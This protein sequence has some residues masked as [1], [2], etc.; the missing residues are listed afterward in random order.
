MAAIPAGAEVLMDRS[1]SCE[2]VLFNDSDGSHVRHRAGTTKYLAATYVGIRNPCG[3]PTSHL[4]FSGNATWAQGEFSLA[5]FHFLR[6]PMAVA[7]TT[8][9]TLGGISEVDTSIISVVVFT[10]TLVFFLPL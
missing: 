5:R 1:T 9:R 8:Q 2:L 10:D 4:V 7:C 3:V 6:R